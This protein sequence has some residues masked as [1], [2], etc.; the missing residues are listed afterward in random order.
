MIMLCDTLIANVCILDFRSHGDFAAGETD[1][2]KI[3]NSQVQDTDDSANKVVAVDMGDFSADVSTD[4]SKD[5]PNK[6]ET[7]PDASSQGEV[8]KIYDPKVIANVKTCQLAMKQR[9]SFS[10]DEHVGLTPL[11]TTTFPEEE[12]VM[13]A[14]IKTT[15]F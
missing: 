1:A 5:F 2:L 7:I 13:P 11:K 6:L 15:S 12:S 9:R 3:A 4:L 10:D 8:K 14:A